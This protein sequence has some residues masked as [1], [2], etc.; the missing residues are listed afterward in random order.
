MNKKVISA[1]KYVLGLGLGVLLLY[2]A[3]R[4]VDFEEVKEGFLKANYLWVGLGLVVAI[5]SHWFRAAR[6]KLLFDAAGYQSNTTNLFAAIMVGYMVNQAVPRAG[7]ISRATLGSRTERIPI[8]VSFGTLVTDRIFD[9]HETP[10]AMKDR[11]DAATSLEVTRGAVIFDAV[12]F[13]YPAKP[14]ME[15]L[16]GVSFE[17]EPGQMIALVGDTGAG[18]STIAHLISRFYDA[19][20]GEVR[21]DAQPVA[22]YRRAGLRR[23]IAIVPQDVVSFAGT[24]RD[25]ITPS[26]L[27]SPFAG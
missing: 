22:D 10:T 16:K 1:L 11:P 24:G 8:G 2:F 23:G 17:A 3:L 5:L 18:K 6:G 25:N 15:I 14:D 7:E 20:G 19:A 21:I 13:A 4:S 26:P 27:R 9:V 12:R